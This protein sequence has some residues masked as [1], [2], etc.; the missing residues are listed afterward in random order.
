MSWIATAPLGRRAMLRSL[1]FGMAVAA[2][3]LTLARKTVAAAVAAMDL[4]IAAGQTYV[5]QGPS[6]ANFDTVTLEDGGEIV[7]QG[8]VQLNVQTLVKQ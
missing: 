7:M 5:L 8:P 6:V 1:A 2:V 3:P 4:V